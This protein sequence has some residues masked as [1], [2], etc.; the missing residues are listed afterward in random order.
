MQLIHDLLVAYTMPGIVLGY[1]LGFFLIIVP[2]RD[3]LQGYRMARQMMGCSYL[4]L[5]M[6]LVAE[7]VSLKMETPLVQQQMIVVSIGLSQAFLFTFTLTTLID[8][9]F[10]TWRRFLREA[11]MV[12]VPVVAGFVVLFTCSD[13]C[14]STAFLLLSAFYIYKIVDYVIHFYRHYRDYKRHMSNYFSDGERLRLQWVARSFIVALA[15]GI[16]VLTYAFFPSTLTSMLIAIVMVA[17]YGAFGIRFINYAFT[18]H[19]IEEAMTEAIDADTETEAAGDSQPSLTED[20]RQLMGR[21]AELMTSQRLYAN[22]NLTIEDVAVQ[23]GESHRAVSA[24]I[25]RC[26]ETNFKNWVNGYRVDEAVGLIRDGY[27]KQYTTDALARQVGF[28]NRISFYRVFKKF[29]G[30]SP[31]NY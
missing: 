13:Q 20:S 5:F 2:E 14:I 17:Y 18:F 27:L 10:F 1:A 25:N 6:A 30:H 28:A 26:Q 3:G 21:L 23:V 24:A 4:V 7:A 19:Q 22:P 15:L 9:Q 29:T 12:L 16:L 11:V 8:V 31:G